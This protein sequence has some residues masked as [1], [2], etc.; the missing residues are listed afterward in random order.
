MLL[1]P[2]PRPAVDWDWLWDPPVPWRELALRVRRRLRPPWAPSG[3]PMLLAPHSTPT[4]GRHRHQ[5]SDPPVSWRELALR[6]R[7][8]LRP[9]WAPSGLPMLLAPY[10]TPVVEGDWFSDPQVAWRGHPRRLRHP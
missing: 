9:P 2:Y 3:L 4:I 7:R 6:V 1:A 5:F 8:R 10:P